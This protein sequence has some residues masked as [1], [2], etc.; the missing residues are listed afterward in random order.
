MIIKRLFMIIKR[1]HIFGCAFLMQ[2]IKGG[3]NVADG[4]IKIGVDLDTSSLQ[5]A[6]QKIGIFA[7]GAM[8]GVQKATTDS[9]KGFDN[10]GQRAAEKA[11]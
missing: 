7:Q 4:T 6:L 8:Q 2:K 3:M 5:T 1:E 9:A 10:L 11:A